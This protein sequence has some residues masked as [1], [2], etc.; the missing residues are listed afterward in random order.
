LT[1]L[2]RMCEHSNSNVLEAFI[3]HSQLG[4]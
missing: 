4:D 1:P 3:L 2:E